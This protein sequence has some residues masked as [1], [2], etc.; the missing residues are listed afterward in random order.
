[1]STELNVGIRKR[2]DGDHWEGCRI[3]KCMWG[4]ENERMVNERK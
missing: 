1:M 3:D 2:E 4:M